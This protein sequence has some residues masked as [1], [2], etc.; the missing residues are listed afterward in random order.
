MAAKLVDLQSVVK[1]YLEKSHAEPVV[2]DAAWV[3]ELNPYATEIRR[4]P[5]VTE[6]IDCEVIDTKRLPAP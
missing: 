1:E 6:D 4:Q 5:I 3:V 2:V